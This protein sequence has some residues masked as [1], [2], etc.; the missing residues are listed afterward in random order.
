MVQFSMIKRFLICTIKAIPFGVF[1]V[2][3]FL[4]NLEVREDTPVT[5][6]PAQLAA[7]LDTAEPPDKTSLSKNKQ[8]EPEDFKD[9]LIS[10][11]YTCINK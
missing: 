9:L 2:P 1:L 5:A 10:N 6:H 11:Y 4:Y 3:S 7:L 8:Q